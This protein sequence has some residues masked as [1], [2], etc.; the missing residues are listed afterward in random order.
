MQF[1]MTVIEESGNTFEQSLLGAVGIDTMDPE[2]IEAVLSKDF[3]S[4]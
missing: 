4:A 3:H 2:N 1:F